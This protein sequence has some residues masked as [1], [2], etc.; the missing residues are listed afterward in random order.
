MRYIHQ[1][2]ETDCGAA[3]LAM[4][5]SHYKSHKSITSI[6]ELAG[7]D[8][9]GTNLTGMVQ[10]AEKMGFSARALKGSREALTDSLPCPF[11]AHVSVKKDEYMLMH[12]VV[13]AG[14][15][16]KKL[17]V[18][19]PDEGTGRRT[20]STAS[21]A[22]RW[23]GYVVFLAPGRTFKP[24]KGEGSLLF[25][26]LPVMKPYKGIL[27]MACLASLF[28]ILF[29]ILSTLYTRY[30]ID[31]IIFSQA[32][33]TLATLSTGMLA[34]AIIQ[35]V[36]G[37]VRK[38]LLTHFAYKID[39]SLV[40]SYFSHVF[41][42]P[43]SFFDSRKTGEILSR[44]QDIGKIQQTLSQATVSVV[45]DA[46]MI[47]V[48]GPVLYITNKTLFAVVLVTVPFSSAVM[49]IFSRLYK[50]RYRELMAS[51]ADVESYL[52][53]AVNGASTIKAMTAED[54]A[55]HTFE[56][57]Q[58]R[59][60]NSG[61]KAAHL[62]IYQETLTGL[63][64]QASTIVLFWAG[65][66]L[67][68]K[69]S[70]STGTL[71]SFSALAGY[72][73]DPLERLVNMQ[74]SCQEAFVAADRLGEILEME[75]E[76]EGEERLLEPAKLGGTIECRDVTF[77]YGTH[78]AV[79]EHLS[80]SI[81]AGEKV[82][83]VGPSGCGKSTLVKLLL[84][85]Y[86]PEH[87]TISVDGHD[88]RDMDAYALRSHIGYVPQDVYLFSGTVAEN[89]ALHYPA[90]TLEEIAEAARRAGANAFIEA[91]PQRY[92]TMLGEKGTNL[93]GGERQRLALA[94]ALLGRPD[95][96]ILDEATSSLDTVSEQ[97]IKQTIDHMQGERLTTIII[98]HRLSTVTD[99][100]R[101]FVM[102]G[103]SIVQAGTHFELAREQGLYHELWHG[104][105]V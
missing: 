30:I 41:H 12:Y 8:T 50:K 43:L 88:L 96:L 80:F 33:L 72:F 15:H 20:V 87:G 18:W 46:L 29:G 70:M 6:R 51:A 49:Y 25:R 78:R 22:E 99:C 45:M 52:V 32:K 105:A 24:E 97:L 47:L 77:R 21:F 34:V 16:G 26:F 95:I 85:L 82:A 31:E 103:G 2:D 40:F 38:I 10:A 76:Q 19:D 90:A 92:N 17:D 9:K 71:V 3:C 5:A 11:I 4:V 63:I 101:I 36:T 74:A 61:W 69:G 53:E 27:F 93:S 39:L 68:I 64:K 83:F 100:D 37:A 86:K 28:L 67:I 60:T 89:I 7:T 14:I 73:T 48:V 102:D 98:A 79:Y 54:T 35:A 104:I 56:K 57:Y 55:I 1:L 59:M 65:S 62:G 81:H 75:C 91:L 66:L 23:T 44:M 42:L 13:V 58:M 94:R 84:K